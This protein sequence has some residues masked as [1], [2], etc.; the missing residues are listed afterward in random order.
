MVLVVVSR[1]VIVDGLRSL[2]LEEGYTAFGQSSMM[3]HPLGILLV[4]S[5]FSRWTYA[6]CKALAFS[7]I[8][9]AHVPGL[10]YNTAWLQLSVVL[11]WITVI[12]CVLRGLPVLVECKRFFN[13]S[14]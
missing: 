9:L 3:Q 5:R 8:I 11:L 10:P 7:L 14:R 4:S 6:V 13:P 1:G 2:A 12:F